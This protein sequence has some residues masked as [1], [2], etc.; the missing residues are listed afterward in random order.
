MSS[1]TQQPSPPVQQATAPAPPS[2]TIHVI[3]GPNSLT[4]VLR[5]PGEDPSGGLTRKDAAGYLR[6][7]ASKWDTHDGEALP[8]AAL[9]PAEPETAVY[10]VDG[11]DAL[12]YVLLRPA[13]GGAV[14][15]EANAQG[16]TKQDAAGYLR[17]IA[18]HWDPL[19]GS[20][21]DLSIELEVQRMK[22]V[23]VELAVGGHWS[24]LEGVVGNHEHPYWTPTLEAVAKLTAQPAATAAGRPDGQYGRPAD[25]HTWAQP[26]P[27][28]FVCF[29]C[30]SGDACDGAQ[31]APW[32][33]PKAVEDQ[34]ALAHYNEYWPVGTVVQFRPNGVGDWTDSRTIT[35]V[36]LGRDL[37]PYVSVDAYPPQSGA[38]VK[39]GDLRKIHNDG[40]GDDVMLAPL[41]FGDGGM[42]DAQL[43]EVQS[44]GYFDGRMLPTK[45]DEDLR[46]VE[47]LDRYGR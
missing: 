7:V 26:R 28:V 2:I 33:C 21:D 17:R 31:Y 23:A 18:K 35:P 10:I 20:A 29:Q 45:P 47:I 3:D 8:R 22:A 6:T 9:T 14:L 12:A 13:E 32:P 46:A 42:T 30:I 44:Q 40:D 25:G 1:P 27:G 37:Q 15:V 11:R 43:E 16:L 34:P 5:K 41:G 36:W 39:I 19:R 38:A 24:Q 4:Y